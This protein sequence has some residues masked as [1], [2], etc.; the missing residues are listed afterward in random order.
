MRTVEQIEQELE[1]RFKKFQPTCV[2]FSIRGPTRLYLEYDDAGIFHEWNPANG[3]HV[4]A[5]TIEKPEKVAA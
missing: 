1:Q 3:N 5:G 2:D 4:D